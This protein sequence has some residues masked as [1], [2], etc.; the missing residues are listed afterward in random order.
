MCASQ[1]P[2]PPTSPADPTPPKP[3]PGSALSPTTRTPSPSPVVASMSAGPS[4]PRRASAT[5]PP[6]KFESS[7]SRCQQLFQGRFPAHVVSDEKEQVILKQSQLQ[8][9]LAGCSCKEC[10]G[11]MELWMSKDRFDS[12]VK[13]RYPACDRDVSET[14][15]GTGVKM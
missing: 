8:S 9:L 14:A 13:I 5:S 11:D 10:G 4:M 15:P 7:L 12:T 3:Q 6:A 2:V 1:P